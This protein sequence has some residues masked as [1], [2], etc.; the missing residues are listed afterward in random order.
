LPDIKALYMQ[1]GSDGNVNILWVDC[2]AHCEKTFVRIC[3]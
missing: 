2:N 3:I 1:I